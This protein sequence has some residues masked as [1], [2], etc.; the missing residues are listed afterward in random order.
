MARKKDSGKKKQLEKNKKDRIEADK[1]GLNLKEYRL[2][3]QSS[4]RFKGYV[5][6]L[7]E[8]ARIKRIERE[9]DKEG[10]TLDKPVMD[11]GQIAQHY[12]GYVTKRSRPKDE[13]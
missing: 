5:N 2:Q 8:Y 11:S 7:N 6:K 10:F 13:Q 9:L 12:N 3:K 4:K 1:L